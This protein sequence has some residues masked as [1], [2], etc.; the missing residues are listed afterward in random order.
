[1][2]ASVR[3]LQERKI[4]CNSEKQR[5]ERKLSSHLPGQSKEH[6]KQQIC[7]QRSVL[8]DKGLTTFNIVDELWAASP[9]IETKTTKVIGLEREKEDLTK[10]AMEH[11]EQRKHIDGLKNIL[12]MK[13]FPAQEFASSNVN[14]V[15]PLP[16]AEDEEWTKTLESLYQTSREKT[17]SLSKH[18]TNIRK[19]AEEEVSRK[20]YEC[21]REEETLDR[22]EVEIDDLERKL[23]SQGGGR[24]N[25]VQQEQEALQTAK[26]RVLEAKRKSTQ[27]ETKCRQSDVVP[28]V[29]REEVEFLEKTVK[30]V[31]CDVQKLDAEEENAK[32]Q[33]GRDGKVKT[34]KEQSQYA[35]RDCSE[36]FEELS[37]RLT[38]SALDLGEKKGPE[39]SKWLQSPRAHFHSD[40]ISSAKKAERESDSL[41]RIEKQLS[42]KRKW[43]LGEAE[44]QREKHRNQLREA[45]VQEGIAKIRSENSLQEFRTTAKEA[46]DQFLL[47]R[48]LPSGDWAQFLS[49]STPSSTYRFSATQEQ[50]NFIQTILAK[51]NAKIQ[52]AAE[53]EWGL[54]TGLRHV[55]QEFE[56]FRKNFQ[57]PACGVQGSD[58]A[59]I[60]KMKKFF[61]QRMSEYE[62]PENLTRAKE[63]LRQLN[64]TKNHL[65]DF[66]RIL[67][68]VISD[69]STYEKDEEYHRIA[70]SQRLVCETEMKECDENADKIKALDGS[71]L[72][73]DR[74]VKECS[75]S[76]QRFRDASD[77]L[78]ELK[79][80][81]TAQ[82][83]EPEGRPSFVV[84]T[85]L[86]Q[87]RVTLQRKSSELLTKRKEL[88]T[89]TKDE[90]EFE[91][92]GREFDEQNR[93]CGTLERLKI[94]RQ[95]ADDCKQNNKKLQD[96]FL[97]AQDILKKTSA[98][99]DEK[100][101][102]V[103]K[104]ENMKRGELEEWRRSL[105]KLGSFDREANSLDQD[106]VEKS[107][108]VWKK[109]LRCQEEKRTLL[110]RLETLEGNLDVCEVKE[111]IANIDRDIR[112]KQQHYGDE[113]DVVG[114]DLQETLRNF[115]DVVGAD[116]QET[117][118]NFEN[119]R[120]RKSTLKRI[121]EKNVEKLHREME[122][123]QV[124][125][126]NLNQCQI[127]KAVV[128]YSS[129]DLKSIYLARDK[130]LTL[131]HKIKMR[132][133]NRAIMKLWHSSYRGTN[134]D[135]IRIG[136]YE[137]EAGK[138][139]KTP[140][141]YFQYHVEMRQGQSWVKMRG[142]CST[143]QKYFACLIVRLALVDMFCKELSFLVLDQPTANVDHEHAG[144]IGRAIN[145]FLASRRRRGNFHLLL[146][147]T[148]REL[149][150]M[151]DAREYCDHC[152]AI[153]EDENGYSMAERR[154]LQEL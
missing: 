43:I 62:N 22:K 39:L 35:M 140:K 79:G 37:K 57:C 100:L 63:N 87:K 12:K 54:K 6:L 90:I 147:T 20:G 102:S 56:L 3:V 70:G 134:I 9:V 94:L 27:A 76:V 120:E 85:E 71:C 91:R 108:E 110:R 69:S 1:M 128:G 113:D 7:E 32:K 61:E 53:E 106:R 142:R 139:G 93:I 36:S 105:D 82:S 64:Q 83:S 25:S 144:Y 95:E 96:S 19:K 52:Q 2:K 47:I 131:G 49:L 149:A 42:Q 60:E 99:H 101:A 126:K 68:K 75:K 138:G 143:G 115:D 137:K 121:K 92:A 123:Y 45:L 141:R 78:K 130:A 133:I 33:D 132:S 17:A 18:F 86:K 109:D 73:E 151:L 41:R 74:L 67:S 72:E 84:S 4:G 148:D 77:Q 11:Q 153:T 51:T 48:T 117:L 88:D 23:I 145:I 114:A 103:S 59:G 65:S 107:L 150:D 119:E 29:L 97:K 46:E 124:V 89:C 118:R 55:T 154:N 26:E 116:L 135:E 21:K 34:L 14:H 136:A 104:D 28:S 152:Y 10:Q 112:E 98:D 16:N 38:K 5:M 80:Y 15:L 146:A 81:L 122:K 58:K 40:D 13:L 127:K 111:R 50:V 31:E 8:R 125:L 129:E 30:A 24:P 44:S 66:E